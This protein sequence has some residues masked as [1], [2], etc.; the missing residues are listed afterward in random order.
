M[1]TPDP[2]DFFERQFQRQVRDAD[3]ALNP[4]E[5]L[6]LPYVAG[7]VLDLGKEAINDP[8]LGSEKR[9]AVT[10]IEDGTDIEV[11]TPPELSVSAHM[12]A[13]PASTVR[14]HPT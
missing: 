10:H 12:S 6:A 3:F 2:V 1:T 8:R 5:Q 7:S 14:S 13:L 11:V 4:F 9:S